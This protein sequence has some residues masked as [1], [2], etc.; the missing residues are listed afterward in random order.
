MSAQRRAVLIGKV[1]GT[2]Y[3]P[4]IYLKP[5][6]MLF[7]ARR[8]ARARRIRQTQLEDVS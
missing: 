6:H 3:W 4:A 2:I 7:I 1:A 5:A 8:D